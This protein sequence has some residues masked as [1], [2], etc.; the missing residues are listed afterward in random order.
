MGR[1]VM[2]ENA[3]KRHWG[4]EVDEENEGK[5]GIEM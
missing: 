3:E 5:E 1:S 2:E 4:E